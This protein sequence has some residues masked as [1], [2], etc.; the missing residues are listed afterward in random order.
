MTPGR[1]FRSNCAMFKIRDQSLFRCSRA[2][3]HS[4]ASVVSDC[5]TINL[6]AGELTLWAAHNDRNGS[7]PLD[8]G[9]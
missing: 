1:V 7:I 9:L 4:Y 5:L 2:H 3:S 8:Q 6:D